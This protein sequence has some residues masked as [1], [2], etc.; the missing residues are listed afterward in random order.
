MLE[1]LL[2]T[3]L[4]ISLQ[5]SLSDEE[6]RALH[7]GGKEGCIMNKISRRISVPVQCENRKLVIYGE[8]EEM[9]EAQ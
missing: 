3:A 8:K 1:E 9:M 5:F 6:D 7:K 2:S 4:E